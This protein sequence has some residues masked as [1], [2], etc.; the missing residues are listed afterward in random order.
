VAFAEFEE[1][2]F[3]EL[4]A[5]FR[6]LIGRAVMV[7]VCTGNAIASEGYGI[8]AFVERTV[9]EQVSGRRDEALTL[10]VPGMWNVTVEERLMREAAVLRP[11][12]DE[13]YYLA[14]TLAFGT[15]VTVGVDEAYAERLTAAYDL[16]A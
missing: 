2:S 10:G 8:A 4:E 14:I 7:Q 5:R 15:T 3:D 16:Q 6:A 12:Q 9:I 1:L 13:H 11:G